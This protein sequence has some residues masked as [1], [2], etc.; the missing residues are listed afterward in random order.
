MV[1]RSGVKDAGGLR[2]LALGL[3]AR[4]IVAELLLRSNHVVGQWPG[5]I[6]IRQGDGGTVFKPVGGYQ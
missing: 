2:D 1:G 6:V 4:L 3:I 5:P